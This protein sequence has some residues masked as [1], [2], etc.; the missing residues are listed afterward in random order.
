[1]VYRGGTLQQRTVSL[2][3]HSWNFL[4]LLVTVLL[5]VRQDA[6]PPTNSSPPRGGE[7]L[8]G[9]HQ[10][11]PFGSFRPRPEGR[12]DLLHRSLG[13]AGELDGWQPMRQR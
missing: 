4:V 9:S 3:R 7:T 11:P 10:S 6:I 2:F 8:L 5:P 12:E 13:S 1:M